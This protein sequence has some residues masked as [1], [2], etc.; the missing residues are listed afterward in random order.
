MKIGIIQASSQREKNAVMEACVREAAPR[1]AAGV[2]GKTCFVDIKI[3]SFTEILPKT[4]HPRSTAAKE[5]KTPRAHLLPSRLSLSV[6][7]SH[8]FN[9]FAVA[10]S[11]PEGPSPPVGTC[12][13][14]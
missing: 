3:H 1:E 14:P 13:P 7:D 9:A 11:C 8:R 10:D 5:R 6:P 2:W 12:T 4:H